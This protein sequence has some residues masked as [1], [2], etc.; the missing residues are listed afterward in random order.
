[1]LRLLDYLMNGMNHKIGAVI[2]NVVTTV[3]CNNQ[4]PPGTSFLV[5]RYVMV[6]G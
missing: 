2:W 5:Y 4:F 1:M 6:R 3:F